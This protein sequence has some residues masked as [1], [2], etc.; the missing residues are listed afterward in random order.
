MLLIF[1]L[2]ITPKLFLHNIFANHKDTLYY[3]TGNDPKNFQLN[4][5]GINCQCINLVAEAPFIN[6]D[7]PI[8]IIAPDFFS[9]KKPG[10]C[11]SFYDARHFFSA[12]RGPPSLT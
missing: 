5:V 7:D 11:L 6:Y 2:S 1:S 9:E 8:Q 10:F 4:K 12:F 3:L